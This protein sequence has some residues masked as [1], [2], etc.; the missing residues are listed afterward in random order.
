M[1]AVAIRRRA[2]LPAML[3]LLAC[4]CVAPRPAAAAAPLFY[5]GAT[6]GDFALRVLLAIHQ[7]RVYGSLYRDDLSE[8]YRLYAASSSGGTA[9]GSVFDREN[10]R[11]GAFTLQFT[12]AAAAGAVQV[13]GLG[14]AEFEAEAVPRHRARTRALA[15]NYTSRDL[16]PRVELRV[17]LRNNGK[18]RMDAVA[19]TG[20]GGV[21]IATISGEWYADALGRAFILPLAVKVAAV[22]G[23]PRERL[24]ARGLPSMVLVRRTGRVVELRNPHDPSQLLLRLR[25]R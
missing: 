23:I 25:R 21:R 3:C 24:P 12:P 15:G 11:V 20:R 6:A 17:A 16:D 8:A 22:P 13:E 4:A 19:G 2:V 10:R 14:S 5:P 18:L 1:D 7:G 9:A